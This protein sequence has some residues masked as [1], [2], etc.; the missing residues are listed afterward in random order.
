M[1]DA[2]VSPSASP[3]V[4]A[5]MTDTEQQQAAPAAAGP[6]T[7][8]SSRSAARRG[9]DKYAARVSASQP[10]ARARDTAAAPPLAPAPAPASRPAA[11]PGTALS[12]RLPS[13]SRSGVARELSSR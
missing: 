7:A 9:S 1:I 8:L 12:S 2:R 10:S 4:A 5:A 3:V 11:P 13:R 6:C